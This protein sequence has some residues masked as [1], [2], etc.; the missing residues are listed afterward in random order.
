MR[1]SADGRPAD[2][3]DPRQVRVIARVFRAVLPDHVEILD[4]KRT[5]E[6]VHVATRF[7]QPMTAP[8]CAERAPKNGESENLPEFRAGESELAIQRSIIGNP[9][10]TGPELPEEVLP[11][12]WRPREDE[13]NIGLEG[14]RFLCCP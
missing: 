4:E 9:T 11:P 8:Q 2:R 14:T 12:L 7:S 1:G 10:G 13:K 6:K 5:A 3:R